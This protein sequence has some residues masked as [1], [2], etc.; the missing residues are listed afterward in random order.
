MNTKYAVLAGLIIVI[1]VTGAFGSHFGYTVEGVPQSV[2]TTDDQP[3]ILGALEWAW[4]NI[5]F[6]LN[7]VAFRVDGM[8]SWVSMIFIFMAAMCV[9]LI[10]SLVRGTN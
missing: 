8:P 4:D 10:A 6:L 9:V 1:L 5:V 2:E 3:G 7:M